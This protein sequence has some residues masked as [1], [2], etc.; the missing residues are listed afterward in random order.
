MCRG[1]MPAAGPAVSLR[2]QAQVPA[3]C[4]DKKTQQMLWADQGWF[5]PQG[6]VS[7]SMEQV[8]GAWAGGSGALSCRDHLRECSA[9][10]GGASGPGR[11]AKQRL[12]FSLLFPSQHRP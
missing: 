1:V 12:G 2:C 10:S 8:R 6:D 5:G 7:L 9:Y 3:P 11:A 4:R